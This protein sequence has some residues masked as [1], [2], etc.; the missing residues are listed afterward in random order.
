MVLSHCCS[1]E[2]DKKG[3]SYAWARKVVES[4]TVDDE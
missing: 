2:I 1:S 4:L 3:G